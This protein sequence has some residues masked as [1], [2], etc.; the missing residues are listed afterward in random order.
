MALGNIESDILSIVGEALELNS[1]YYTT[2]QLDNAIKMCL[3]DLSKTCPIDETDD[4][5]TLAINTAYIAVPTDY[6]NLIAI[7]LKDSSNIWYEPLKKLKGGQKEYRRLLDEDS[8]TD[9]PEYY[10]EFDDYF[11]L[12]RKSNAVYTVKIEY[13]RAHPQTPL[14]ILY[15][16]I[17]RSAI[18]AGV[19]Y[20]KALLKRSPIH[21]QHWGQQYA[22]EKEQ[23]RQN[24]NFQPSISE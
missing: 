24:W 23:L 14:N 19:C 12:W 8:S 10:S 9:R 7:T 20:F 6:I 4:S 11:W 5:K 1:S 22:Y 15:G 17:A 18:Y 16:E 13:G 3:A 2:G 21:I